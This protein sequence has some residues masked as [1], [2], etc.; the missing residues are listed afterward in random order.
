VEEWVK[1]KEVKEVA[2]SKEAENIS[3]KLTHA[4]TERQRDRE[5]E[6]QRDRQTDRQRRPALLPG[7]KKTNKKRNKQAPMASHLLRSSANAR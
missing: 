2:A 1:A 7:I 3:F 5:T 4:Y 6:R